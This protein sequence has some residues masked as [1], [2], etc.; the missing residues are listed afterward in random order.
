[1]DWFRVDSGLP[2]HHKLGRLA[3]TLRARRE[4]VGWS[5][6]CLWAWAARNRE[7]G[8]L[9]GLDADELAEVSAWEGES[10][11][12]LKAL[13]KCKLIDENPDGTRLIHGWQ[14]RQPLLKR[15]EWRSQT[16]RDRSTSRSPDVHATTTGRVPDGHLQTD[17][18]T[19]RQT[20]CSSTAD[21]LSEPSALASEFAFGCKEQKTWSPTQTQ[22]AEWEAK[23]PEIDVRAELAKA[24][25][26]SAA[27][28]PKA[29]RWMPTFCD[30]WL[31]RSTPTKGPNAMTPER[32]R[33]LTIR[34][35][36]KEL[37]AYRSMNVPIAVMQ[38]E[39]ELRS[40]GV[41]P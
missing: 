9:S 5:L 30:S 20:K 18:Q 35:L 2:Q 38:T 41:E 10:E 29:V 4:H 32:E 39:R 31:R 19:D 7:D 15:R 28:R 17:I 22:V 13:V 14:D 16:A 12:W 21:S 23:Y 8:D 36:R 26:W 24:A 34:Q 40:L 25:E 33:E 27:N 11:P 1:M 6:I 37:A 3:R